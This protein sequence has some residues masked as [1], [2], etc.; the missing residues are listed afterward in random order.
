MKPLPPMGK[1]E[2]DYLFWL[3]SQPDEKLTPSQVSHLDF[4]MERISQ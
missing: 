4:L 2:W 1:N 3:N